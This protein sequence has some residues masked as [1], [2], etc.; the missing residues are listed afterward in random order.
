MDCKEGIVTEIASDHVIVRMV[1]SSACSGCHAKGVCHSGDAKEEL[2]T[3][4]SYPHGLAVGEKVRI[5]FS[6]SKGL[7]AVV[8]AFVIPLIFIVAGVTLMSY[9]GTSE[10]IMLLVLLLF[11]V[12]Y[13]LILS[14]FKK[15]FVKAFQIKIERI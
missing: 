8:Y 3:V 10:L 2:L 4:T 5:L 11:M 14:F 1:R 15:R 9:F 12:G 7:V 13:Y 6:D